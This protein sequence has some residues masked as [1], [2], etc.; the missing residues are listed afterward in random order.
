MYSYTYSDSRDA[1]AD[2]TELQTDDQSFTASASKA[3][4]ERLAI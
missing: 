2:A 3:T 4:I 1:H